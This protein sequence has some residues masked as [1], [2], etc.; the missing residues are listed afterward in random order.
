MSEPE[1]LTSLQDGAWW[2][3]LNRPQKRNA[4]SARLVGELRAAL[5]APPDGARAVVIRGA[6]GNL[7]AGGDVSDMLGAGPPPAD[8]GPDPLAEMNRGYGRLLEEVEAHPLPVVVV[9]EGA[10]MGGGFGLACAADL[11]LGVGGARFR[12]PEVSLGITPAQIAP[13]L[14][15]RLG[16]STARRLALTGAD[17]GAEEALSIGLCHERVGPEGVDGALAATLAR[18]RRGEPGALSATKALLLRTQVALGPLLDAAAADFAAR[19][20]GEAAA[21]GMTA[22]LTRSAPPWAAEGK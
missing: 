8:G 16:L 20:R 5:A 4:L 2:L 15:R 10:V 9:C 17:L 7:C 22:F 21:A 3:V 1:L 6:G 11:S 12:L 14:V 13:F 18:L 19:A